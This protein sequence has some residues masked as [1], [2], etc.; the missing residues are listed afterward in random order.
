MITTYQ[1]LTVTSRWM[2]YLCFILLA[3][4]PFYLAHHWVLPIHLWLDSMPLGLSYA[5]AEFWP[6]SPLKQILGILISFLP[7]FFVGKGLWH[8]RKL[9]MLYSRG[10]FFSPL[11]VN[12]Y[13]KCASTALWFVVTWI[14]S[15]SLLSLA[16]TFDTAQPVIS[17]TFTHAHAIALF[18][19]L[20]LRVI[21]WIMSVAQDLA[22]ENQQFV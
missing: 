17:L 13:S 12:L 18:S 8:L 22:T 6:P 14:A 5:R 15:L 19:A 9:F 11:H 7:G 3:L 20:F 1:R 2:S 10:D 4:L 16:M 21:T